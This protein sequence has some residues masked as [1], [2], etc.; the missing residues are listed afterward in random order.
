MAASQKPGIET[1]ARASV[2][3]EA[4][5]GPAGPQGSQHRKPDAGHDPQERRPKRQRERPR[6]ALP[7]LLAHVEVV[8]VGDEVAAEEL[9]HRVQ[10]LDRKRVVEAPLAPDHA[11]LGRAGLRA[12]QTHGGIAVWDRVED[13]EDQHRHGEHHQQ[14]RDQATCDE[15]DHVCFRNVR[16]GR[17]RVEGAADTVADHVERQ[18]REHDQQPGGHGELRGR[19]E[20]LVTVLDQRAPRR[21]TLYADPKERQR[22]LELD[23]VPDD[24][25]EQHDQRRANVR[26]DLPRHD[27]PRAHSGG[28]RGE[29]ELLLADR[30]D[31]GAS[32][33]HHVRHGPD[34]DHEDRDQQ[35]AARQ[36]HRP[37]V[38]PAHGERCAERDP[39]ED[40]REGPQ[41]VDHRRD[42]A[43]HEAARVAGDERERDAQHGRCQRGSY[44]DQ[45]RVAPAVKEPDHHV[46]P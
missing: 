45:E 37:Q 26:Q 39:Q 23:G 22:R 46:P 6:H 1:P 38:E 8:E 10:V 33:P 28:A 13:Q 44:A 5:A 4:I 24:Q 43:V 25:R 27:A 42:R 29:H 31:L 36:L 11:D 34:G 32:R 17:M 7:D 20:P 2:A 15:P 41:E 40:P 16:R 35:R 21:L 18:D 30:P 14:H 12:G 9:L 3:Q 19:G